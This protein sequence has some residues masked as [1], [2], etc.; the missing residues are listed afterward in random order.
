[1][2]INLG[3]M[4]LPIHVSQDFN[5]MRI[6]QIIHEE[7]LSLP[8]PSKFHFPYSE[9]FSGAS[10]IIHHFVKLSKHNRY[11]HPEFH[12]D[13]NKNEWIGRMDTRC[14]FSHSKYLPLTVAKAAIAYLNKTDKDYSK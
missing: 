7:L 8:S 14:K 13:S 11:I 9:H 1:M 4:V 6:D 3:E 12:F 10:I 2:C 5:T